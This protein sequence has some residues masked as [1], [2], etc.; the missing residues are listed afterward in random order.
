M[1][2]FG[3]ALVAAALAAL[4]LAPAC[5]QTVCGGGQCWK[6]SPTR[7]GV[8]VSPTEYHEAGRVYFRQADGVFRESPQPPPKVEKSYE[9][10]LPTGVEKDKLSSGE[11]YTI[12]GVKVERSAIVQSLIGDKQPQDAL[13]DDSIELSVSVFAPTATEA[14]KVADELKASIGDAGFRFW[15]GT[16]DDW[17]GKPAGFVTTGNPTIYCQA[18]SGR[19][20]HRQDDYSGG[21]EAAAE[22]IRKA[23]SDYDPAKDPD[24]RQAS[25]PLPGGLSLNLIIGLILAAAVAYFTRSKAP[26]S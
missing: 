16:P 18:P 4:F 12:N 11:S 7:G 13:S 22:A 6:V 3:F 24:R 19:V 21:A 26:A 25:L 5:A 15:Y 20:L 17:A 10:P 14:R 9:G 2:W 1:R 23:R 8:F